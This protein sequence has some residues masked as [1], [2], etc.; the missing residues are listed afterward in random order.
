MAVVHLQRM[1]SE[2]SY[3]CDRCFQKAPGLAVFDITKR[4]RSWV[5]DGWMAVRITENV[6]QTH[7]HFCHNCRKEFRRVVDV[8][9]PEG[10][11]VPIPAE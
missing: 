9:L 2:Y 8:F 6:V 1:S 10:Q 3:T 4:A 5:L 7:L 11:A